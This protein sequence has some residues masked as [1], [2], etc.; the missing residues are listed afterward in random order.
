MED[1]EAGKE[2]G[3]WTQAER[4]SSIASFDFSD[5]EESLPDLDSMAGAFK[6]S[7]QDEDPDTVEYSVSTPAKK[8]SSNKAQAWTGDFNPKDMAAGLRTVLNKEKEG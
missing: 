6:S 4:K 1:F 5:S 7:S 8:Q 2:K 3:A